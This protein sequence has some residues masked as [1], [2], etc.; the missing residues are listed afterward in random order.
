MLL[1]WMLKC[2]K[3]W[4]LI[5]T[6]RILIKVPEASIKI[7]EIPVKTPVISVVRRINV[8]N[9]FSVGHVHKIY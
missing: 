6:P 4:I 1:F 8:Y 5:K 7:P 9:I 3:L 2:E